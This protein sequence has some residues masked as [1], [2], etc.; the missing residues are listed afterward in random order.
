MANTFLLKQ[1][2]DEM[3]KAIKLC[4]ASHCPTVEF[5]GDN[6]NV[7]KDDFGGSVELTDENMQT[8]V[9]VYMSNRMDDHD[10]TKIESNT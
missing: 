3:S 5:M 10:V 9:A 6:K 1:S 2:G 4:C 8:L 7:I